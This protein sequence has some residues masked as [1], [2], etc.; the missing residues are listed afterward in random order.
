MLKHCL[1]KEP[2]ASFVRLPRL[3]SG[4]QKLSPPITFSESVPFERTLQL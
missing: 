4:K 2:R 3:R 1:I